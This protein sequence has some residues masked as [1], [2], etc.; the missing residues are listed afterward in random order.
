MLRLIGLM[1]SIGF[2]DSLNPST[3][4]PAMYLAT[5]Q[6]NARGQVM[7]FTLAV[8][9]VYLVGGLAVALGPGELLLHLVPHPRPG[10]KYLFEIIGGV[11]LLTLS[12]VLWTFRKLLVGRQ[13]PEVHTDGRSSALLGAT[14][15]A[16]EL[17]TAFPYFAA[18]AAVVG[19]GFGVW[20]Q[21]FLILI[22]NVAFVL[23]LLAIIAI[24]AVAGSDAQGMLVAARKWLERHW[25]VTLAVVGLI[26][27]LFC[28]FIGITGLVGL[29]RSHA[30]AVAR[31]LRGIVAR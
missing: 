4:A 6:R 15:T 10:L 11:V 1:I 21:V 24:L 17:P 25:P 28:V 13:L 18:I 30:G 23:P 3:I 12:A 14:I 7:Q 8:F 16:V 5:D 27:G 26:A 31:K 2:A 29:H 19:S 9:V 20:H 22:F